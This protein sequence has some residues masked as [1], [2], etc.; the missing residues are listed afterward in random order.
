MIDF[1]SI[2]NDIGASAVVRLLI[3]L[4]SADAIFGLLRAAK[5]RKINSAIGIDGLIR[6]VTMLLTMVVLY[7]IDI[8]ININFVSVV[9]A[10]V[11]SILNLP[12]VGLAELFGVILIAFEGISILKNLSLLG[13]PL[14]KFVNSALEKF[15]SDMTKEVG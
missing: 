7:F 1:L 8:L 3:I 11:A 10:E 9:P 12:S 4:I 2:F 6:K 13:I 15:L 5:E 14:P